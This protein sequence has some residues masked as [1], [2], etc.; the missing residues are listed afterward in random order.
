[1]V[2]PAEESLA[3]KAR[4][5]WIEPNWSGNSG[6]YFRVLNPASE[7]QHDLGRVVHRQPLTDRGGRAVS[8]L[9]SG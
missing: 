2:V 8:G 9:E 5:S 4:V 7:V 1:V 3:E 6:R